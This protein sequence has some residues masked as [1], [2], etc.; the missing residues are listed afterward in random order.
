M[1]DVS[2]DV[3]ALCKNFVALKH[4]S[5][6]KATPSGIVSVLREAADAI[7][8]DILEMGLV[9]KT[10]PFS[11]V[12]LSVFGDSNK[13]IVKSAVIGN[14]ADPLEIINNLEAVCD[15]LKSAVTNDFLDRLFKDTPLEEKFKQF[16]KEKGYDISK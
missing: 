14:E 13:G 5:L 16:L 6:A 9:N 11:H 1:A 15:K 8:K 4:K 10:F 7:E 12:V 3:R 2:D